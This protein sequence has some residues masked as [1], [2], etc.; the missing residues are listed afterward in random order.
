MKSF[1]I[2]PVIHNGSTT[3]FSTC[4]VFISVLV[5]PIEVARHA[6]THNAIHIFDTDM[7]VGYLS[8]IPVLRVLGVPQPECKSPVEKIVLRNQSSAVR[9]IAY[10]KQYTTHVHT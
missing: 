9:K 8:F 5:H 4:E 7:Y 10:S 1:S 3:R 6:H 2:S